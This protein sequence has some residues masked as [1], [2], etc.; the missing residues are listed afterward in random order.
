[1]EGQG[2]GLLQNSDKPNAPAQAIYD[3]ASPLI[4]HL[5]V[6]LNTLP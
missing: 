6:S 3:S 1:M 4:H 5:G 2:L